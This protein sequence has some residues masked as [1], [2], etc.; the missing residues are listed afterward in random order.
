[1]GCRGA[2]ISVAKITSQRLK[3]LQNFGLLLY[4]NKIFSNLNTDFNLAPLQSAL[5]YIRLLCKIFSNLSYIKEKS[6][7]LTTPFFPNKYCLED[8]DDCVC[9]N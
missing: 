9:Y 2:H 4:V 1:M 8:F 7:L 3:L 5:S 6:A